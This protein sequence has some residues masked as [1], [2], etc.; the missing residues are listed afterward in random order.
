[1]DKWTT[2]VHD[3][4]LRTASLRVNSQV[5]SWGKEPRL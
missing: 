4:A 5:T 1:M 2:G 3:Y